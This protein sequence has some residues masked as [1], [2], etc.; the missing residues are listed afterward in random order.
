MQPGR[1]WGCPP[2]S[3]VWRET[4]METGQPGKGVGGRAGLDPPWSQ[5]YWGSRER[6]AAYSLLG[7]G[8]TR[9]QIGMGH[10]QAPSSELGLETTPVSR[11]TAFSVCV[12]S[13]VSVDNAASRP[14]HQKGGRRGCCQDSRCPPGGLDKLPSGLGQGYWSGMGGTVLSQPAL[15]I[16]DASLC[17][18]CP[19]EVSKSRFAFILVPLGFLGPR[20]LN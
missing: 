12:G 15:Q 4:L 20:T 1:G 11:K 8:A 7:F 14:G 10:G 17:L 3:P 9:A 18:H 2:L 5:G 6:T 19:G 13:T 16:R